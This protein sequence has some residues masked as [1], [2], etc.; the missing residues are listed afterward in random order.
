[1]S[2]SIRFC[3]FL[4]LL[5][6]PLFLSACRAPTD[7]TLSC[8]NPVAVSGT[9]DARA[10]GFIVMFQTGVD[11]R[12]EVARLSSRYEFTPQYVYPAVGGFAAELSASAVAGLRCE[13]TVQL[14]G[15]DSVGSVVT[16]AGE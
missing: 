7:A 10:P 4:G 13:P 16:R 15:H 2:T 9:F 1:M 12:P 11:V 6:G 5:G 14:I 8:E 3:L